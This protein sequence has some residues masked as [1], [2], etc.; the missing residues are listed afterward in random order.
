MSEPRKPRKPKATKPN[1]PDFS[2]SV[3]LESA[4]M[5]LRDAL[6]AATA[7]AHALQLEAISDA[8]LSLAAAQHM[9]THDRDYFDQKAHEDDE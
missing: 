6:K 5:S 7:E 9:M 1:L 4:E 3:L 8:L 2:V